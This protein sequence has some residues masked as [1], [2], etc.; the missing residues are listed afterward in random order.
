MGLCGRLPS[1]GCQNA[2]GQVVIF[3]GERILCGNRFCDAGFAL[4]GA[5]ADQQR[6]AHAF[7]SC[8]VCRV[9]LCERCAP[10]APGGVRPPCA[11]CG[12]VLLAPRSE[13]C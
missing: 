3:G 12:T 9:H 5:V 1:E 11:Y 10:S 8:R 4:S 13:L 2:R 7:S 6:E